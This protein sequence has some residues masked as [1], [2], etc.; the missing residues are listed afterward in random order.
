MRG[1]EKT[2][3]GEPNCLTNS[4]ASTP[5]MFRC[6]LWTSRKPG[7]VQA[8]LKATVPDDILLEEAPVGRFSD[9][10]VILKAAN[11]V[12]DQSATHFHWLSHQ[13]RRGESGETSCVQGR[14]MQSR[15]P[16]DWASD[17]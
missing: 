3:R 2:K 5:L 7:I 10:L 14:H 1:S 12:V 6:W 8:G 13:H 4:I 11:K 17:T 9:E 15:C 16:R